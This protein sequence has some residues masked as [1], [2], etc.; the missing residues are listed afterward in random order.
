MSE[1]SHDS[2]GDYIHAGKCKLDYTA[3]SGIH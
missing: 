2:K 3:Q 1:R